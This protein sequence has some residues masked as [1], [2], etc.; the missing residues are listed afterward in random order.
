MRFEDLC[1]RLTVYDATLKSVATSMMYDFYSGSAEQKESI[2]LS[3]D[4]STLAPGRYETRY[5]FFRRM[6]ITDDIES[7][8]GLSFY[9]TES[10]L[11]AQ[12]KWH[13]SVRLVP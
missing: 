3:F 8:M 12:T 7:Y 2:T 10:I 6:G 13:S 5:T 9:K 4:M 11:T 1:F